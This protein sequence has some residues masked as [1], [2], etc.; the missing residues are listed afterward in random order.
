MKEVPKFIQISG[1]RGYLYALDED[2]VIWR[3]VPATLE[4]ARLAFW[5]KTLTDHPHSEP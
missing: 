4:P 3:H 5:T 2:G 1:G